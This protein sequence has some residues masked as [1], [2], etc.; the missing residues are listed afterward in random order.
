MDNGQLV[1]PAAAD[2]RFDGMR[3]VFTGE[4][5]Y[6]KRNHAQQIV[7]DQGGNVANNVSGKV[8]YLVVSD[9]QW[10]DHEANG[11]T[12]TKLRRALELQESCKQ[13]QTPPQIVKE[14]E[15]YDMIQ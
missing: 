12:T 3:F 10:E 6:L 9:D 13:Y 15:F 7:E 1:E 2:G 14:P 8:N 5:A 11:K 4:L